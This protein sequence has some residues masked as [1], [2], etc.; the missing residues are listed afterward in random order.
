MSADLSD[1]ERSWFAREFE[2]QCLRRSGA[3]FQTFFEDV[4]LRLDP[5]F[6]VIKPWGKQGDEKCDGISR[7]SATY[8]QVYSPHGLTAAATL[9]KIREDFE[10]AKEHWPEMKRWVFVWSAVREGLPPDVEHYLQALRADH[11][12]LVIDDWSPVALWTEAERLTA[13][14]LR[15]VLGWPPTAE[16]Q[17]VSIAEVRTLLNWMVENPGDAET[18]REGFGRID[19][20][21]KVTLNGLSDTARWEIV[22]AMSAAGLVD[23]YTSGH[24]DVRYSE[25]VAECLVGKYRLLRLRTDDPNLIFSGLVEYVRAGAPAG[26]RVSTAAVGVVAHYFEL[27]DLFETA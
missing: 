25:K 4:M 26:E 1:F 7:D 24:P 19:I 15:T 23:Q 27:C 20:D 3:E 2:L 10:G 13:V 9:A 11:P 12:D 8:Y 21:E 17:D 6:V 22:N 14:D 16:P 18:V 5:S